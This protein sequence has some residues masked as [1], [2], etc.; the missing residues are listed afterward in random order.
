MFDAGS[1]IE[2][3]EPSI[4]TNIFFILI[5]KYETPLIDTRLRK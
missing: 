5:D 4:A 3:S 2:D 1:S